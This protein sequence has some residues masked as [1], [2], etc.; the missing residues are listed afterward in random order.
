MLTGV[1]T[2]LPKVIIH[3]AHAASVSTKQGKEKDKSVADPIAA[4]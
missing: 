3:L 2:D 4:L 1:G